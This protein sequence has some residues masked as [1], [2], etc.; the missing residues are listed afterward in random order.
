M[1]EV[2]TPAESQVLITLDA[3]KIRLRITDGT[4]DVILTEL[5]LEV[6]DYIARET[7]RVFGRE[8]VK[9]T[10]PGYARTQLVL[11]RTPIVNISAIVFNSEAVTDFVIKDADSGILYREAGW[12][13]TSLVLTQFT[14]YRPPSTEEPK[15][16]VSYTGGY[17]LPT[18]AAPTDPTILPYDLRG[19][20]FSYLKFLFNNYLAENPE[21]QSY[22]VGDV[23][24]S[25]GTE[26]NNLFIRDLNRKLLKWTRIC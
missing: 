11:S 17:T 23:S 7:D 24:E 20:A 26:E 6:S 18:F 14:T 4:H 22:R 16:E 21:I 13:W 2:I 15:Y 19:V 1:I 25:R 10:L 12:S 3:A 9:E 5:I 8:T